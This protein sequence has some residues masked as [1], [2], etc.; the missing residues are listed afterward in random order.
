MK[1]ESRKYPTSICPQ[2]SLCTVRCSHILC[3]PIHYEPQV[4]GSVPCSLTG[5]EGRQTDSRDRKRM[6]SQRR[7]EIAACRNEGTD[8]PPNKAQN[9]QYLQVSI[10][11]RRK[12][13]PQSTDYL[14][15]SSAGFVEF[16]RL[17]GKAGAD[18]PGWPSSLQVLSHSP[19][20]PFERPSLSLYTSCPAYQQISQLLIFRGKTNQ[21]NFIRLLP[22]LHKLT[23][24]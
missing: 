17:T 7:P 11:S 12:C 16:G 24:L 10:Q 3:V 19:Q 9:T 18:Y 4:Q 2:V 21:Q 22:S 6:T 8:W 15:K 1:V 5:V 23:H 20:Q 13:N 14:K